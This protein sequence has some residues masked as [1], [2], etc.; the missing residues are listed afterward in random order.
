[1]ESQPILQ[2]QHILLLYIPYISDTTLEI[3]SI[4]MIWKNSSIATVIGNL[5]EMSQFLLWYLYVALI[6]VGISLIVEET[7]N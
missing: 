6:N 3:G 2:G 1:M 4:G 7:A 5:Y